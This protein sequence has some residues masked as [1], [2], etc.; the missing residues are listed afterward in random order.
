MAQTSKWTFVLAKTRPVTPSNL[1]SGG[2]KP[3][4]PTR[5]RRPRPP[6]PCGEGGE[7]PGRSGRSLPTTNLQQ[8]SDGRLLKAVRAPVTP[9]YTARLAC[10]FESLNTPPRINPL[11]TLRAPRMSSAIGSAER[12]FQ[13]LARASTCTSCTAPHLTGVTAMSIYVK[14]A[15]PP[16]VT[17]RRDGPTRRASCELVVRCKPRL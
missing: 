8:K 10:T 14:G 2:L 7:V 15:S 11:T 4:C 9:C 17:L 3:P 16:T 12:S 6:E 13:A 5:G 1:R